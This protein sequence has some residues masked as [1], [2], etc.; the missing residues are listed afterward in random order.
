[1]TIYTPV[2]KEIRKILTPPILKLLKRNIE[3][4]ALYIHRAIKKIKGEDKEKFSLIDF[5]YLSGLQ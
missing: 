5:G 3:L 1:M 4:D 2:F